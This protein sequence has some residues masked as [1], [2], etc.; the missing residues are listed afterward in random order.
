MRR[1]G[2]VFLGVGLIAAALA[3]LWWSLRVYKTLPGPEDGSP[4][5]FIVWLPALALLPM[6]ILSLAA[7]KNDELPLRT[8]QR[9]P[10]RLPAAAGE[11]NGRALPLMF[12]L[13]T[14]VASA[15]AFGMVVS[16][17]PKGWSESWECQTCSDG[18]GSCC[19]L[20]D[21]T[22]YQHLLFIPACVVVPLGALGGPIAGIGAARYLRRRNKQGLPVVEVSKSRLIPG[23]RMGL[24]AVLYG[25]GPIHALELWVQCIE[26]AS[27]SS[28]SNTRTDTEIA[29]VELIGKGEGLSLVAGTP[30]ELDVG[31]Q[32]PRRAM[33]SFAANNNRIRWQ[34]VVRVRTPA[35]TLEQQFALTIAARADGAVEARG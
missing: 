32:V 26:S 23:E 31:W 6:G 18:D 30:Y 22:W 16:L 14:L 15:L 20:I 10:L 4:A 13:S 28:G 9:L 29:H 34:L 8:Q 27:Y 24:R 25:H 17:F 5:D 1:Q 3:A 19:N 33:H 7:A 35:L 11:D 21:G 12:V 2:V